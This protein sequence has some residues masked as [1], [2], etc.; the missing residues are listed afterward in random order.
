MFCRSLFVLFYFFV[1]HCVVYYSSIYGFWLPL[2]YLQILLQRDLSALFRGMQ[3]F[4]CILIASSYVVDCTILFYTI[5]FYTDIRYLIL[6]KKE[7][8]RKGENERSCICVL[9]VLIFPLST[10]LI[11]YFETVPTV[12]YFYSL[13]YSTALNRFEYFQFE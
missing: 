6:T 12:W 2:R 9:G 4:V 3:Y 7:W 13:F 1:G 5:L 11:L 8:L 10:T